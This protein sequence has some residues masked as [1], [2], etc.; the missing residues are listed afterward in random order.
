MPHSTE[1]VVFSWFIAASETLL[2]I[3][4]AVIASWSARRGI[5]AC[6]RQ[7]VLRAQRAERSSWRVRLDRL[8]DEGQSDARK[9]QRADAV[10]RVIGHVVTAVIVAVAAI[11]G[12]NLLGVDA[13]FAISSAGFI[14][15][16]IALSAQDFVK[17]FLAGI[18]VLLEDRYAVGDV[19]TL[20]VA[21]TDVRGT[22][23]L[24][25]TASVRVRTAGGATWHAGH[26]VIESVTNES[27]L[28]AV[29]G[30][31][32]PIAEWSQ[33]DAEA[34]PGRL[35]DASND[36]GLTGVVFVRDI[37]THA[38]DGARSTAARGAT[39]TS[40]TNT[41]PQRHERS[42]PQHAH[43]ASTIAGP[44]HADSTAARHPNTSEPQPRAHTQPADGTIASLAIDPDEHSETDRDTGRDGDDTSGTL[45]VEVRSNRPLSDSQ[46]QLVRERL[47][48]H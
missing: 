21:G 26:H 23:D 22:V 4:L 25:G 9:R 39:S 18:R 44:T 3:P 35:A 29:T 11:I 27:Q 37:E 19:V 48:G 8:G 34:A 15:F 45:T 30:I 28:P 20:S 13:V 5:R 10:A 46:A 7:A 6:T 41:I 40:A 14:G 2:L 36:V 16:A 1:V 33:A 38:S 32:V 24:I 42:T 43:A 17:D 12:L 31:D 47:L